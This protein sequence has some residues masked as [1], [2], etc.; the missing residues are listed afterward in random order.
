MENINV[1]QAMREMADKANNDREMASKSQAEQWVDA[2]IIPNI[3]RAAENGEYYTSGRI[4]SN[5]HHGY[6][7]AHLESMGFTIEKMRDRYIRITW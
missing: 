5:I 1:A 3:K 6:A 4:P 2:N 7:V